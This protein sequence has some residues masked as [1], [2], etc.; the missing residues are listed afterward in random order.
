MLVRTRRYQKNRID[1]P[2]VEI[3][4]ITGSRRQEITRTIAQRV[5]GRYAGNA[6]SKCFRA[7]SITLRGSQV[8]NA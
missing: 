8:D 5:T 4:N 7:V 6:V 1:V 3:G 2:S